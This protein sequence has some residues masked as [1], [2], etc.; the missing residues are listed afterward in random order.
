MLIIL[1]KYKLRGKSK[2]LLIVD[3][4][5]DRNLVNLVLMYEIQISI[6]TM[7]LINSSSLFSSSLQSIF[8][9]DF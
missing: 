9:A 4:F 2:S 6:L 3:N 8:L 7:L 1:I 5:D